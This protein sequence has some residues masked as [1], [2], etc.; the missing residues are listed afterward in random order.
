M[1]YQ[2]PQIGDVVELVG[3]HIDPSRQYGLVVNVVEPNPNTNKP[4]WMDLMS[5]P[6][7]Y[8]LLSNGSVA[9][10]WRESLR[11]LCNGEKNERR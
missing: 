8:V 11:L 4:G 10:A 3:A 1:N 9:T 5:K 2:E 7:Y 6:L